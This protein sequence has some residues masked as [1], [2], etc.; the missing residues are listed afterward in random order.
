MLEIG[1]RVP[2]E[3]GGDVFFGEGG[4]RASRCCVRFIVDSARWMGCS[5]PQGAVRFSGVS[6]RFGTGYVLVRS[7]SQ[8]SLLQSSGFSS[9]GIPACCDIESGAQL[10]NTNRDALALQVRPAAPAPAGLGGSGR[11]VTVPT[12]SRRGS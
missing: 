10:L 3:F 7:A 2:R 9:V 12:P 1:V 8:S 6:R 11:T 5:V 4:I